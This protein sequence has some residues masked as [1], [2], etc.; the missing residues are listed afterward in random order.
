MSSFG[1]CSE[2]PVT[3]IMMLSMDC[4]PCACV[5]RAMQLG[6]SGFSRPR[7]ASGGVFYILA[8]SS[9]QEAW[10]VESTVGVGLRGCGRLGAYA[11][12][13]QRERD[14]IQRSVHYDLRAVAIRDPRKSRCESAACC[15][16]GSPPASAIQRILM[17][18]NQVDFSQ[19]AM[20]R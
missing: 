1:T 4:V 3:R 19:K 17:R 12:R 7:Q 15:L 2:S 18:V 14:A 16:H 10:N 5:K 9:Q 8:F 6:A 11:D 13:L 20:L